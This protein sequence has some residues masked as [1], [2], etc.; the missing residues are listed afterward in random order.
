MDIC[1]C[2]HFC[3]DV[4]FNFS[5]WFFLFSEAS[6]HF[7]GTK[8]GKQMLLAGSK[9]STKI[10][11]YVLIHKTNIINIYPAFWGASTVIPRNHDWISAFLKHRG[12]IF[13][14]AANYD[15]FIKIWREKGHSVMIWFR[16]SQQ[17]GSKHSYAFK[18]SGIRPSRTLLQEENG[19]NENMNYFVFVRILEGH[20]IL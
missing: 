6:S 12:E 5:M 11:R 14:Q 13:G 3:F 4:F 20:I 17:I 9:F 15:T 1:Y 8:V 2:L 19:T 10:W 7:F 16:V 18:K